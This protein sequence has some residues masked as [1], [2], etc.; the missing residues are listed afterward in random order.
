MYI[1]W[2]K[3]KAYWLKGGIIASIVYLGLILIT[4]ILYAQCSGYA[5]CPIVWN[6]PAFPWAWMEWMSIFYTSFSFGIFILVGCILNALLFFLIGST[7][8]RIIGKIKSKK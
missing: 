4:F 1:E 3:Q 7:I 2:F 5:L 6:Y 8:G